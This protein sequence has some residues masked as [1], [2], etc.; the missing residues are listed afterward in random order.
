MQQDQLS[1]RPQPDRRDRLIQERIH[2]P[3][4]VRLKMPDAAICPRCQAVYEHGRWHWGLRPVTAE[5]VVCQACHRIA[6]HC[7]AGIVML[8]G[9]RVAAHRDELLA[10]IRHQEALETA[11]HPLSRIMET[12]DTADGFEATTTDIHLPRRIADA[13]R[14]S[15][16][17]DLTLH[18]DEGGYFARVQWRA[19]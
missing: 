4:K 7:P 14:R 15:H 13:L 1:H 3:Y 16:H 2:D 12:R 17:G 11:E 18:Y 5:E 10:L 6:D 8:S 9:P 19:D